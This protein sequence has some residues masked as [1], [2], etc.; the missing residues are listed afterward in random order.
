MHL[1]FM[2][3][4]A[5][6]AGTLISAQAVSAQAASADY[7]ACAALNANAQPRETIATC[8]TALQNRTLADWQRADALSSRGV[9]YRQIGENGKSLRDLRAARHLDATPNTRRMLAWTWHELGYDKTAEWLYTRVLKDDDAAQGWLSRCVVRLGLDKEAQAIEDCREALTR[10][11]ESEDAAYFGSLALIRL[12]RPME[13]LSVS[14]AGL[15]HHD[16]SARL[17]LNKAM[18]LALMGEIEATRD[19]SRKQAKRFPSEQG[20]QKLLSVLDP[21]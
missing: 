16:D 2:S 10:D 7:T 17:H 6:F 8:S 18:A 12:D 9:A 20:F 4:C 15:A 3:F 14:E 11:P 1:K 19:Y 21:S 13:A 5:V